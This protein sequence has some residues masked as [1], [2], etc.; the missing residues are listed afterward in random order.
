[1]QSFILTE[2]SDCGLLIVVTSSSFLKGKDML[3]EKRQ[4]VQII[5]IRSPAYIQTD[6]L[7]TPIR[8]TCLQRFSRSEFFRLS[9]T[10]RCPSYTWEREKEKERE[11]ER[12]SARAKARKIER[13]REREREMMMI[14]FN[15]INSG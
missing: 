7:C 12:E 10:S 8:S 13:K 9:R 2:V 1:M 4:S 3:K 6:V 11:R 14:A 5:K 15:T